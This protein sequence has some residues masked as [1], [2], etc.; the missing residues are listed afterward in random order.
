M[1]Y[2]STRSDIY[3][4]DLQAVLQGLAPDG[5]LFVDPTLSERRFDW[6]NCLALNELGMMRM[7]LHHL[8]PGF[9]DMGALVEKP[10]PENLK[11]T[12]FL[13]SSAAG[14][15]MLWSFTTVRPPR[16]RMWRCQCCRGLS[17]RRGSRRE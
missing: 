17:Q 14:K 7:I 2:K 12:A 1:N 6:K 9:D 8:L 3:V 13:P 15:I 16:S 10:T 11:T 5:G 4:S